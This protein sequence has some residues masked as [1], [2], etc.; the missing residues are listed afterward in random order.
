MLVASSDR[1]MFAI[2]E[3]MLDTESSTNIFKT[4]NC[5]PG[6]EKQTGRLCSAVSNAAPVEYGSRS[7]EHFGT[8][9]LCTLMNAL[10]KNILSFAM[11]VDSGADVTY[12]KAMDR[13]TMIPASGS[14]G[15]GS[16]ERN[17]VFPG[18]AAATGLQ[19]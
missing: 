5:L 12:D 1:S 2:H 8:S 3:V 17:P 10:L 18:G 4:R 9:E 13:F 7:K 14:S 16:E 15:G 6:S 11:Q 19:G